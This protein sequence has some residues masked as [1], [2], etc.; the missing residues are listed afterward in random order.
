MPLGVLFA[1]IPADVASRLAAQVSVPSLGVALIDSYYYA[2]GANQFAKYF[3]LAQRTALEAVP[4][5]GD[6]LVLTRWVEAIVGA[7]VAT[8]MEVS[9]IEALYLAQ[10]GP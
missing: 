10:F 5:P 4:V 1:R 9:L 7:A 2:I 6:P 3:V 8:S